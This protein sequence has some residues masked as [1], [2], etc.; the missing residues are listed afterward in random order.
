MQHASLCNNKTSQIPVQ[1]QKQTTCQPMASDL[2][3]N[4]SNAAR[5]LKASSD[6]VSL[7][8]NATRTTNKRHARPCT[9]TKEKH[10]LRCH[11]GCAEAHTKNNMKNKKNRKKNTLQP[12][13]KGPTPTPSD[14]DR[15]EPQQNNRSD[16]SQPPWWRGAL[17]EIRGAP[18]HHGRGQTPPRGGRP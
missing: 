10:K 4:A 2:A 1:N 9:L 5:S 13:D 17:I 7:K 14:I 11:A 18:L 8:T 16:R 15:C 6:G 3:F 12:G